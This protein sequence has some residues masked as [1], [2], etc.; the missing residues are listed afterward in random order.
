MGGNWGKWV[1]K[2]Q[3]GGAAPKSPK[4]FGGG[5]AAWVPLRFEGGSPGCRPQPLPMAF[6]V[7]LGDRKWVGREQC[8]GADP[9][10][11]QK[12]SGG[13]LSACGPPKI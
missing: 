11:P 2:E 12:N 6:S 7:R 13:V 4:K 1:G 3:C 5:L 10:E 9:K 8:G